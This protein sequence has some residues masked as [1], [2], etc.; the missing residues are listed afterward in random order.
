MTA[1]GADTATAV[2]NAVRPRRRWSR[3]AALSAMLTIA[4]AVTCIFSLG[5]GQYALSPTQIVGIL[6]DALGVHTAW[7]PTQATDAG[8]LLSIRLPRL[9]PGL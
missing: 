8:V 3:F 1:V 2:Q 9:T 6:L 4:L 5:L 7:A